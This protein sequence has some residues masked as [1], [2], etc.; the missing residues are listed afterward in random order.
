[1]TE[2]SMLPLAQVLSSKIARVTFF[3][4]RAEVARLLRCRV[5][6]G[7]CLAVVTGVT[8]VIDDSSL[9]AAV[10]G[11]QA[12]VVASSVRRAEVQAAS[13]RASERT[14]REG[15]HQAA[16]RRLFEAHRSLDRAEAEQARLQRLLAD[17]ERSAA[18]AAH[19]RADQTAALRAAYDEL[20]RALEA[21]FGRL[22]RCRAEL[23]LAI[24]A[25]RLAS[26]RQGQAKALAPRH[27]A[28]VEIQL[29]AAEAA[30]VEVEITYRT[31]CALWRPEHHAQLSP[32]TAQGPARLL[33]RT[34]AIAWQ[35][36]G[37]DWQNVPCRFSTARPSQSAAP[38]LLRD[39]LLTL[40]RRADPRSIIIE[41]REQAVNLAT[42]GR[43]A[44]RVEEM[45]GIDDGGEPLALDSKAPASIPP[46]GLPVAIEIGEQAL[47]CEAD[48]VAFPERGEAAHLRVTST[49]TGRIPLL[50]GPVRVAVGPALLGVASTRYIAPGEPFELGFGHDDD[51]RVRRSCEER[52][53]VVPVIGT[54]KIHRRVRLFLSNLGRQPKTMRVVE[55]V[56]VSELRDLTV[57]VTE[58]GGSRLDPRT[59]FARFD[60]TLAPGQHLELTFGYR[61]E[62]SSRVEM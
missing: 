50:A 30:E 23:E 4:D 16:R 57:E 59:G 35:S 61:I 31:P 52:R 40:Q 19:A 28:T 17:W 55:R 6:P 18:R 58:P 7:S 44:R 3:E 8:L 24:E 45:P 1:M 27:E 43:G 39:D 37:E 62:A 41:E 11:G 33:I 56:P 5:T 51:V 36:T 49:W 10:R 32:A 53:E 20:S 21:L 54:Q 47:P 38:P 9:V 34:F 60:L 15:E 25:E 2:P 14:S 12:R 22:E 46:D 13:L 26:T 29:S 48:L 42:L